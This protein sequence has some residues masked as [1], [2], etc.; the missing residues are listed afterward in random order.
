MPKS[1]RFRTSVHSN[2]TTAICSSVVTTSSG[3]S[4]GNVASSGARLYTSRIKKKWVPTIDLLVTTT[5]KA[6]GYRLRAYAE[7]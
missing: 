7:L 2:M 1:T 5:N 4:P 6:D 3:G